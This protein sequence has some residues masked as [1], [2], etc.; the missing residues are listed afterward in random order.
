[1]P[2]KYRN[3]LLWE[4]YQWPPKKLMF[5]IFMVSIRRSPSCTHMSDTQKRD[6][7]WGGD[8]FPDP[9]VLGGYKETEIHLGGQ[10]L[11]V[12]LWGGPSYCTA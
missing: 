5:G 1:M 6:C 3:R 7:Y 11:L 8:T 4:S 12:I 9:G 2:V 10:G